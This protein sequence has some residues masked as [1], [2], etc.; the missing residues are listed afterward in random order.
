VLGGSFNWATLETIVDAAEMAYGRRFLLEKYPRLAEE[1]A[2][3][4]FPEDLPDKPDGA[5]EEISGAGRCAARS[6]GGEETAEF[7]R[8]GRVRDLVSLA[9]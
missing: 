9:L 2:P 1:E 4:A 8:H 5:D 3:L 7:C 6:G